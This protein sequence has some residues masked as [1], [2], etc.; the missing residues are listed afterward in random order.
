MD[1]PTEKLI[2]K[3]HAS[4]YKLTLHVTGGGATAIGWL[5]AVPGCSNTLIEATVP[6][7]KEALHSL[8]GF[9]SQ[10]VSCEVAQK[11]SCAG[12]ERACGEDENE[13]LISVG[14]TATL[15]TSREKHSDN[16]AWVCVSVYD[17]K[18][19]RDVLYHLTFQKNLRPR[20]LEDEMLS[21]LIIHSIAVAAGVE[22]SF[23]IGL[24]KEDILSVSG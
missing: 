11:L 13:K 9:V 17:G 10:S 8:I 15:V 16:H 4:G 19:Q 6:Y 22:Q 18:T 12:I 7:S 21:K 14:S 2:A 3:I 5:Q 20:R 1:V 23:D 24:R